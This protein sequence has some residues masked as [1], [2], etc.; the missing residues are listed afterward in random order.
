MN[1]S[2]DTGN[3]KRR[4]VSNKEWPQGWKARWWPVHFGESVGTE[5]AK[6]KDGPSNI[7]AWACVIL[8]VLCFV[9]T[10]ALVL[11]DFLETER[12]D[13]EQWT[14]RGQRGDFWGGH[15]AAGAG[16]IGV[17]LFVAALLFQY[18]ELKAQREDLG[19]HREEFEKSTKVA[20]KQAHVLEGQRIELEKQSRTLRD[21][22]ELILK[23]DDAQLMLALGEKAGQEGFIGALKAR[24]NVSRLALSHIVERAVQDDYYALELL[25]L[26]KAGSSSGAWDYFMPPLRELVEMQKVVGT[27]PGGDGDWDHWLKL[28]EAVIEPREE[29]DKPK[30]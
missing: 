27:R 11:N 6:R 23:R 18:S 1:T 30:E 22:T 26:F 9:A 14:Q 3:K 4:P 29:P 20:E 28:A 8:A 15:V 19:L 5:P 24:V 10:L 17:F 7:G 12:L 2:T 25:S 16:M 13:Q 21:Q